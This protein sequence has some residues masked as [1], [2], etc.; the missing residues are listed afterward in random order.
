MTYVFERW[1][2]FRKFKDDLVHCLHFTDEE[3][4]APKDKITCPSYTATQDRALIRIQFFLLAE[5]EFVLKLGNLNIKRRTS[6]D[7]I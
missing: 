3:A 4:E 2:S 1:T 6:T 7:V 5:R